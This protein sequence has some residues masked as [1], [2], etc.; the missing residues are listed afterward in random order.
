MNHKRPDYSILIYLWQILIRMSDSKYAV[1]MNAKHKKVQWTEN[2]ENG[3]N[4]NNSL[5]EPL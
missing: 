1:M 3:Q 5:I 4:E 2:M